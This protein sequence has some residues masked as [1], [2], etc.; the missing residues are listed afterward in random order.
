M[1]RDTR[2]NIKVTEEELRQYHAY[3]DSKGIALSS[4]IRL[5]L[6]EAMQREGFLDQGGSTKDQ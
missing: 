6:N 2:I 5:L 1:V 3:A 4:L